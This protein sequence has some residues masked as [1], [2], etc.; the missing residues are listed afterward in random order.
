MNGPLSYHDL[1][2]L[3]KAG[4]MKAP[5]PILSRQWVRHAD[6]HRLN[7]LLK[8]HLVR[9]LTFVSRELGPDIVVQGIVCEWNLS[10]N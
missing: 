6:R 4:W 8:N 5:V 7:H 2:L 10:Q 3:E 9:Y 1:L